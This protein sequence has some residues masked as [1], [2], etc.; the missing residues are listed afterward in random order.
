M[1][2][3]NEIVERQRIKLK[4]EKW[5]NTIKSLHIHKLKSMWYDDRP[6][7]TDLGAVTDI[8]Y[9]SGLIKRT[10]ADGTVVLFGKELLGDDLIDKYTR[11]HA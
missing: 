6:Q 9:N 4:A 7:D 8:E 11:Y 10:L 1:G 2:Q 3:F 5:A